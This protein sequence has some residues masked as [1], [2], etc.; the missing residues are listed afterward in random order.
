MITTIIIHYCHF[1]GSPD[2]VCNGTDYKGDQKF[3]CHECGGYGTLNPQTK[4]SAED[5]RAYQERESMRGIQRVFGVV[6]RT[7]KRWL[8]EAVAAL[9][10]L[11]DTLRPRPMRCW[12]WTNYGLLC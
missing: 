11:V 9:S 10:D 5:L 7:L 12:N 2:I 6:Q 4:Y 1:C 8:E 3:R